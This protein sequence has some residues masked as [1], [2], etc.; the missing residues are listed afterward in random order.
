MPISWCIRTTGRKS[1]V[2]GAGGEST[3]D[4]AANRA[5]RDRLE[6][7]LKEITAEAQPLEKVLNLI[8]RDNMGANVFVNWTALQAVVPPVDRN[9]PVTVSLKEVPFRKALTTILSQ[10]GGGTANLSYTIDERHHHDL[11]QGRPQ[12]RQIPTGQGV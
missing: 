6:E 10:V 3:Q 4:S 5:V 1:R 9:T 2:S 12:Q 11:D 7:N 8:I